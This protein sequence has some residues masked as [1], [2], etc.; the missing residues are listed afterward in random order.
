MIALAEH[1][2]KTRGIGKS[3]IE[4]NSCNILVSLHQVQEHMVKTDIVENG[5]KCG[6]HIFSYKC[7]KVLGRQPKLRGQLIQ[8][9]RRIVIA[10]DIICDRIGSLFLRKQFFG[11]GYQPEIFY[12]KICEIIEKIGLARRADFWLL[13]KYI[14]Q[15]IDFFPEQMSKLRCYVGRQYCAFEESLR[16][17]GRS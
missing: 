13:K 3:V 10:L 17:D 6:S 8:R 14:C 15:K 12:E 4:Q 11:L 16:K 1:F 9:D 2:I 5:I 7:R